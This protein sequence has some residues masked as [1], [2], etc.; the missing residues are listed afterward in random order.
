MGTPASPFG[1]RCVVS[2]SSNV[3]DYHLEA[4]ALRLT[5]LSCIVVACIRITSHNI[6]CTEMAMCSLVDWLC[7][8][9][10]RFF[11]KAIIPLRITVTFIAS[12]AIIA[13]RP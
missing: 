6:F 2:F 10:L 4:M 13:I 7:I 3:I 1:F 5:S 12:A 9:V 8:V 11:D